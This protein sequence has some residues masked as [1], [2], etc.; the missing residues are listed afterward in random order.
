MEDEPSETVALSLFVRTR[1]PQGLLLVLAN[2]TSQ[3]LRVWLDEGR[4]KVQI[5]NFETLASHGVVN[6]GQFHPVS[7]KI[8]QARVALFLSAR[9]QGNIP[10]RNVLLQMGDV[11][12]VGGL[13]DR[14]ASLAFGGYF[15]GCVQDLR[16]SSKRLQFY[17]IGTAVSSYV[18]E[19][20]VK[21]TR[22]CASDNSCSVSDKYQQ[23][24]PAYVTQ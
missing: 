24:I 11:L 21:V 18:Q 8:E 4:V 20:L 19:S 12:Y 1:R 3:Y 7:V 2:S 23:A 10:I 16:M 22:G 15:K 14:R 5:N 9:S 17:P 6:D 13:P